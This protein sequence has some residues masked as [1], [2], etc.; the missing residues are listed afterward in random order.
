MTATLWSKRYGLIALVGI[1][2]IE[3]FF[4]FALL[5]EGMSFAPQLLLATICVAS[6]YPG[7]DA[8]RQLSLALPGSQHKEIW[9]RYVLIFCLGL[10]P[11]VPTVV[12]WLGT[13]VFTVPAIQGFADAYSGIAGLAIIHCFLRFC[14]FPG[15]TR[16]VARF[17]RTSN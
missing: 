4:A 7:M 2:S 13:M 10:F 15:S 8:M 6:L 11:L 1:M 14:D 12:L 5:G 17:L 3:V 16:G 9:A